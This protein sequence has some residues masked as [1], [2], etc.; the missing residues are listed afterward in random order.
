MIERASSAGPSELP[1]CEDVQEIHQAIESLR[2][3]VQI[4]WQ[5]VDEVR[6]VIGQVVGH[7]AAEF[8]NVVPPQGL[9]L[10]RYRPFAGYDPVEEWNAENG[11]AQESH[12]E[13]GE[14]VEPTPVLDMGPV[15]HAVRRQQQML[16][17]DEP[18][19]DEPRAERPEAAPITSQQEAEPAAATEAGPVGSQVSHEEGVDTFEHEQRP[20][21]IDDFVAFRHEFADGQGQVDAAR[22]Q[23]E[24]RRMRASKQHFVEQLVRTKQPISY[25]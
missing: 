13:T 19:G 20:F 15:A 1:T 9:L 8:W 6:D 12:D 18:N 2:D 10:G 22:I 14:A 21:S 23:R 24:F 17:L 25:G 5:A 3:H 11:E 4:V 16:L 7:D